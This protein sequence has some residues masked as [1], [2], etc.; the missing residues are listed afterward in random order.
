MSIANEVQN[1]VSLL[2]A[3]AG[4]ERRLTLT[5]SN[6]RGV[7]FSEYRLLQA[8]SARSNGSAM[9]VELA[10]AVGLT[11]SAVTRA[12]KPLEKL[13]YVSTAKS[14]R[15]A[16]RSLAVLTPGGRELL[17]DTETVVSEVV[18]SLALDA[19]DLRCL[20]RVAGALQ[21]TRATHP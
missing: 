4:L 14:E 13:G 6:I 9:R 3:A 12:L 19:A 15:D 2:S 20:A 11:P 1:V 21:R 18:Q 5:L 8:L 17:S 7:S 16:R 10:A